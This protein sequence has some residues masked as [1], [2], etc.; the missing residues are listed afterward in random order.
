ME[1]LTAAASADDQP[2]YRKS[3]S[4]EVQ[5]TASAGNISDDSTVNDAPTSKAH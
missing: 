2:K 5:P 4:F 1:N 3:S